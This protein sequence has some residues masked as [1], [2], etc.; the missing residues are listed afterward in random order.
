MFPVERLVDVDEAGASLVNANRV[1]GKACCSIRFKQMGTYSKTL[2]LILIL[3]I[4]SNNLKFLC[5]S[6]DPGTTHRTFYEFIEQLIR[7]I[8]PGIKLVL[9]YGIT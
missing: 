9:L 8:R 5:I 4:G 3:A 1:I 6:N 2:T 7:T